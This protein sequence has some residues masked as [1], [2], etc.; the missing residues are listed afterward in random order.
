MPVILFSPIFVDS[1]S[2][3]SGVE[4]KHKKDFFFAA[5]SVC[6]AVLSSCSVGEEVNT[7]TPSGRQL[8]ASICLAGR[9]LFWKPP[10]GQELFFCS[11]APSQ[12]AIPSAFPWLSL[13]S[14]PGGPWELSLGASVALPP[15]GGLTCP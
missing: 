5:F 4:K 1:V 6:V 7:V 11:L 13:S 12:P 14:I 10:Q 8:Y 3:H 15:K 2:S 9:N